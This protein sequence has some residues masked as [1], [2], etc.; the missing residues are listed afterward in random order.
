MYQRTMH[1]RLP[2]ELEAPREISLREGV[3]IVPLVACIVAIALYPGLILDRS[4]ASVERSLSSLVV[5]DCGEVP[6]PDC[7]GRYEQDGP[8]EGEESTIAEVGP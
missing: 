6:D 2:L 4:E 5:A 1:N 7:R 8:S 3:V